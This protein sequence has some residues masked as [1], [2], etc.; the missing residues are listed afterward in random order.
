MIKIF[1][2]NCETTCTLLKFEYIL[3]S[4]FLY[5]ICLGEYQIWSLEYEEYMKLIFI[6]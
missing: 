4:T 5:I 6:V 1:P 3:K 2:I